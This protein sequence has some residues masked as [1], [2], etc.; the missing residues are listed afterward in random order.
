MYSRKHHS[1]PLYC[2]DEPE[3]KEVSKGFYPWDASAV[4][5]WIC[6][7]ALMYCSDKI[8]DL[9]LDFGLLLKWFWKKV[10]FLEMN[11][12]LGMQVLKEQVDQFKEKEKTLEAENAMLCEKVILFFP[13][14]SLYFLLIFVM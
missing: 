3:E 10:V 12:R 1:P 14:Y 9:S 8:W 2:I 13:L 5:Q 4:Q 7:T 11:E 6:R